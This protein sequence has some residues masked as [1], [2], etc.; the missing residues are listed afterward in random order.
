MLII[1]LSFKTE[2]V[3]IC[4]TLVHSLIAYDNDLF[5]IPGK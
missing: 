1:Q 5:V 2:T 3:H 4:R